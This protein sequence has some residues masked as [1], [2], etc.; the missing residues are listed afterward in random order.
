MA[1]NAV[2]TFYILNSQDRR[3][4]QADSEA[5]AALQ[6]AQDQMGGSLKDAMNFGKMFSGAFGSK[7]GGGGGA[8]SPPPA[9]PSQGSAGGGSDGFGD[10]AA[11]PNGPSGGEP[12]AWPGS[13]GGGSG[14]GGA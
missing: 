14:S 1:F 9:R 3:F 6:E 2:L 13:S 10:F 12:P 11:G 4:A 7:F 5:K 8:P